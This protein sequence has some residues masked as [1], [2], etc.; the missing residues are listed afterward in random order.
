[1]TIS[2]RIRRVTM[3]AAT[4]L[5]LGF[6][7]LAA[8]TPAHAQGQDSCAWYNGVSPNGGNWE[9]TTPG[10]YAFY[11]KEGL[12]IPYTGYVTCNFSNG[13]STKLTMQGDG[14]FVYYA[15]NGK[16]WGS[17]TRPN[18]CYATF[19]ADGN[20]VVRNCAGAALWASNTH[21]YPNAILAFQDDGNLVIYPSSS[22]FNALWAT[23]T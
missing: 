11:F 18:G 12:N 6:G 22:D 14:N 1:M 23:G 16:R 17:N 9:N 10:V 2:S 4:A 15:S 3:I 13:T 20:L 5:A 21:T 8:A 19:Q 7:G